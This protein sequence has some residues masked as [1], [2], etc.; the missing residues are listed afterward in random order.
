[1]P[2][3]QVTSL[4]NEN[5]QLKTDLTGAKEAFANERKA[6]CDEAIA[7]AIR[8]GKIAEADKAVWE[9]RLVRDFANE[10]KALAAL[11]RSI[12][13]E[14]VT[15]GTAFEKAAAKLKESGE[16]KEE[17]GAIANA[18]GKIIDLVAAKR[19]EFKKSGMAHAKAHDMA[20]AH[21]KKNHPKLFAA[22]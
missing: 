7:L 8:G 6:R 17:E 9:G 18:G 10:S 13:T 11:P 4:A 1:M 5:T 15:E 20:Y 2:T 19:E 12:K 16:I 21:V 22:K 3:K 14:G